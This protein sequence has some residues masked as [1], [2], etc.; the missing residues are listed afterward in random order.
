MVVPIEQLCEVV[1]SRV[2]QE[3]ETAR[4]KLAGKFM[5]QTLPPEISFQVEV[6][7]TGYDDGDET[8]TVMP[9]QET[10]TIKGAEESRTVQAPQVTRETQ[11]TK[12][13]QETSV[14]AFGRETTVQVEETT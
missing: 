9:D 11:T 6:V 13:G 1:V 3:I 4:A 5:I 12:H 2:V 8:H 7:F 14:Q 10:I